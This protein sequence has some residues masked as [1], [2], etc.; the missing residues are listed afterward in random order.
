MFDIL[1]K[2]SI[3]KIVRIQVEAVVERLRTKDINLVISPETIAYL[4]KQGYDPHYGARPLKRLI[5]NKILTQVA[6]L[7]I[8]H[9]VA[10]GGTITV[11]LKPVRE[12]AK[13][14]ADVS[15]ASAVTAAPVER[16]FTFD[17]KKKVKMGMAEKAPSLF[18]RLICRANVVQ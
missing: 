8:T 2:E 4:G 15:V 12:S 5:Q 14:G 7:M 6:T 10:K 1:S 18:E 16:E 11:G 9:G 13:G 3:E 17:V